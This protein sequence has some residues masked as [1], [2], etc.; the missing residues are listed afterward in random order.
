MPHVTV[1][2]D[3]VWPYCMLAERTLSEA[4]G[5]RDIRIAWR[6]FELR[7]DSVPT[8][9]PEDPYLPDVWRKSVYPG[10]KSWA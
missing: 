9:R 4:I 10:L 1:Y 5:D 6:P 8:L 7:P 2:S 3:Y